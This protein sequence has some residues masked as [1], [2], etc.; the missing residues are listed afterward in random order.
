MA[1]YEEIVARIDRLPISPW[2]NFVRVVLGFCTFFDFYDAAAIAYV[3]PV[4]IGMWHL[5]PGEIGLLLSSGFAGQLIGSAFFGWV[6]ERYGRIFALNFSILLVSL[7]GLLCA[8]AWSYPAL[9]VLRLIQGIGIGG[10][11]PMAVTY[12]NEISKTERRGRFVG[13][14]QLLSPVGLVGA[15]IIGVWVVPHLGWQWMFIIGAAPAFAMIF[16]RRS[17]PESPRW[18]ARHGRLAE[19]DQV[20]QRIEAKIP[21]GLTLATPAAPLAPAQEPVHAKIRDLFHGIY[22]MRTISVWLLWFCAHSIIYGLIIWL[23]SLFRTVYKLPLEQSLQYSLLANI[24]SLAMAALVALV[25]D[26]VGRRPVLFLSYAGAAIALLALWA[27]NTPS[28]VTVMLLTA[29]GSTSISAAGLSLWIYASEVYP[30]PMRSLGTGTASAWGRAA[31]IAAPMMVGFLLS[32]TNN[33]GNVFLMF[34]AAGLVGAVVMF[35]FGVETTGKLLEEI[36]PDIDAAVSG[37]KLSAVP[38]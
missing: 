12:V 17:I 25:I 11:A 13:L 14:F 15:A 2:H 4:V 37:G 21:G 35:L 6:G 18:L 20:L 7:F 8:F 28:P 36:S 38:R 26:H 10:E 27:L 3:L 19:A 16:I 24:A 5:S 1:T 30:T 34:A 29:L 22:L 33:V 31:A 32:A 9:M 23:P